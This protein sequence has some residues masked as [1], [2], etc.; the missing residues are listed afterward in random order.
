MISR[1]MLQGLAIICAAARTG[2][3]VS[4]ASIAATAKVSEATIRAFERGKAWPRQVEPVVD[5][6][7]TLTGA[8]VQEL[9]HDA[10]GLMRE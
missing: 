5:A 9:W 10:A 1:T 4:T 2:S 3:N 6:Y 8:D 7:A